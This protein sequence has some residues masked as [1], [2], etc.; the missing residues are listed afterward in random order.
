MEGWEI[1]AF[2]TSSTGVLQGFRKILHIHCFCHGQSAGFTLSLYYF[3]RSSTVSCSALKAQ[4]VT[5]LWYS[6]LTYLKFISAVMWIPNWPCDG[7]MVRQLTA[8]F[9][10]NTLV[11]ITCTNAL[12]YQCTFYYLVHMGSVCSELTAARWSVSCGSGL[13]LKPCFYFL[14]FCT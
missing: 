5:W 8:W 1:T 11:P 6:V 13:Q 4:H 14:V 9:P 10:G 3:V 12:V 2:R 7:Q